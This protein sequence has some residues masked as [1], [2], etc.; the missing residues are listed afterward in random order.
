[1]VVEQNDALDSA[2]GKVGCRTL[3]V[4]MIGGPIEPAGLIIGAIPTVIT[5]V[6]AVAC[7]AIGEWGHFALAE[8]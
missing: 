2:A 8:H 7:K 5:R 3:V 6:L 4:G 1:M